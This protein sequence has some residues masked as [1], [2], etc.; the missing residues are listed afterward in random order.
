M[1]LLN[2]ILTQIDENLRR[3]LILGS[4]KNKNNQIKIIMYNPI[5]EKRRLVQERIAKSFDSGINLS[6]EISLEKAHQDGEMHPN[7]KLVWV[8]SAN[9]GRGDWRVANG[10]THKKHQETNGKKE[11]GGEKKTIDDH[12]S[13]ASVDALKRAAADKNAKPEVRE[14]A[15]KELE[16]RNDGTKQ[17]KNDEALSSTASDKVDINKIPDVEYKRI[18]QILEKKNPDHMDAERYLEE[19]AMSDRELKNFH[20]VAENFKNSSKINKL[21]QEYCRKWAELA[22][23]EMQSRHSNSDDA[24]ENQDPPKMTPAKLKYAIN[25]D[26]KKILEHSDIHNDSPKWREGAYGVYKSYKSNNPMS[27]DKFVRYYANNQQDASQGLKM[28]LYFKARENGADEKEAEQYAQ[29]EYA[30]FQKH[31]D[32]PV[33][34]RSKFEFLPFH[35]AKDNGYVSVRSLIDSI[36]R[37]DI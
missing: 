19:E 3:N 36:N 17:K 21:T 12:A 9:G 34:S 18:T 23:Q 37:G 27:V 32:D 31:L 13:G 5:V 24:D 33:L 4:K 22:K 7:G 25:S 28:N 14:A 29:N 35:K 2:Y 6:E 20:A 11:G 26:L 15:K 30:A 1:M 8:A 16:K 10:R